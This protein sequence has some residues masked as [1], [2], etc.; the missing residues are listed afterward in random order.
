MYTPQQ[1][2]ARE[3]A[4]PEFR[5]LPWEQQIKLR[6]EYMTKYIMSGQDQELSRTFA[7]LSPD[8]QKE[9]LDKFAFRAPVFENDK[10]GREYTT[11][12]EQFKNEQA[13][14]GQF[15]SKQTS[16]PPTLR[17]SARAQAQVV[18]GNTIQGSALI[19]AGARLGQRLMQALG[20][21]RA[22]KN[23]Q[24]AVFGDDMKKG[25]KWLEYNVSKEKGEFR[26]KILK[27]VG[28][29]AGVGGDL[30]AGYGVTQ[31]LPT[32]ALKTVAAKAAASIPTKGAVGM[33][34]QS[35]LGV[36]AP[37]A[38][39]TAGEGVTMAVRGEIDR[40]LNGE[41]SVFSKNP[42]FVEIARDF[43]E[44][45]FLDFAIGL[46]GHGI[47]PTAKNIYKMF[48][49]Y[50]TIE[51]GLSGAD[52]QLVRSAIDSWA[53]GETVSEVALNRLPEEVRDYLKQVEKIIDKHPLSAGKTVA[54]STM[55]ELNENPELIANIVAHNNGK[56]A[57]QL[58]DGTWR[59]RDLHDPKFLE[60]FDSTTELLERL[61]ELNNSK[62][63][64]LA[65]LDPEAA[66]L[67]EGSASNLAPFKKPVEGI[68][69][70][71]D[72]RQYVPDISDPTV[73]EATVLSAKKGG[74][75][76]YVPVTKRTAVNTNEASV[77]MERA[78]TQGATAL[79]AHITDDIAEVAERRPVAGRIAPTA[80]EANALIV[81]RRPLDDEGFAAV[82]TQAKRA[83]AKYALRSSEDDLTRAFALREGYDGAVLSNGQVVSFTPSRIRHI[84]ERV[85]TKTGLVVGLSPEA[86]TLH[87]EGTLAP[88]A[89][90]RVKLTGQVAEGETV[91]GASG[92][93]K[94]L[95]N[96][97]DNLDGQALG[98]F[99]EFYLKKAET[100]PKFVKVITSPAANHKASV[101]VK[102]SG[103]DGIVLTVPAR[104]T[105]P[106]TRQKFVTQFLST[107]DA[108]LPKLNKTLSEG[109]IL[110][111]EQVSRSYSRYI[112]KYE[113]PELP[114]QAKRQWFEKV[115]SDKGLA[116]A[117][118]EQG[119][120]RRFVLQA[121]DPVSTKFNKIEGDT[122]EDVMDEF[123]LQNVAEKQL[124]TAL[125]S[126]GFR[127]VRVRNPAPGTPRFRITKP[128][129][130]RI[131]GWEAD[132]IPTL[133]RK[134]GYRPKLSSEFAPSLAVIDPKAG[135]F[136]YS[137]GVVVGTNSSVRKMLDNFDDF[138][139]REVERTFI[140]GDGVVHFTRPAEIEVHIPQAGIRRTF[141]S[142][143]D[144]LAFANGSWRDLNSLHRSAAE[145]GFELSGRNGTFTLVGNGER[146]TAKDLKELSEIL[147]EYPDPSYAPSFHP[148]FDSQW[149]QLKDTFKGIPDVPTFRPSSYVP[150]PLEEYFRTDTG[151]VISAPI[152]KTIKSRTRSASYFST[153]LRDWMTKRL[154]DADAP[155][156][157]VAF[158][159]LLQAELLAANE[160]SRGD[161]LTHLLYRTRGSKRKLG[162]ALSEERRLVIS[163]WLESSDKKAFEAAH[164]MT[165]DEIEIASATRDWFNKL[166]VK[167]GID[168]ALYLEDYLP[169]VREMLLSMDPQDLNLQDSAIELVTKLFGERHIPASVRFW[170]E[171]ARIEEF[172]M[173]FL[174]RDPVALMRR[175]NLHG[176]RRLYMD[177]A[178]KRFKE[179]IDKP[180]IPAEVKIASDNYYKSLLGLDYSQNERYLKRSLS[181]FYSSLEQVLRQSALGE[182]VDPKLMNR[183]RKANEPILSNLWSVSYASYMGWRPWLV[184]R[185]SLQPWTTVAPRFGFTPVARA[186]ETFSKDPDKIIRTLRAEGHIID[187]PPIV[188]DLA[189]TD[190]TL[191]A[192]TG[193][194]L[195]AFTNSDQYTRAITYLTVKGEWDEALSKV[196]AGKLK[197]WDEFAVRSQVN[198]MRPDVQHT[199]RGRLE[200]SGL[201]DPSRP[202]NDSIL[203][204]AFHFYAHEAINDTMFLYRKTN[205]PAAFRAGIVGKLFGQFGTYSAG[206]IQNFL[207]GARMGTKA[208]RAAYFARF[209]V[210]SFGLYEAFKAIG[211]N[212]RN[213]LPWV[214]ATFSGGPW[215]SAAYNV[216][217]AFSSDYRGRQAR[218]ELDRYLPVNAFEMSSALLRGEDVVAKFNLPIG[219]VPGGSEIASVIK[220]LQYLDEGDTK[221]AL[222]TA[223][224][225]P[226][227]PDK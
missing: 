164:K 184:I 31:G 52:R 43:G 73:K 210:A 181:K 147:R 74:T 207:T 54:N 83:K 186:V 57:T 148:E 109:A 64:R 163:D 116:L 58:E 157:A 104:I 72:Y 222:L 21:N 18:I 209:A 206:Y 173:L 121:R 120:K 226:V 26:T 200:A 71:L 89:L 140:R 40:A 124:A 195:R 25:Q 183:L 180:H 96:L 47:I 218:A 154:M 81:L 220:S 138:A 1:W 45:A 204:G 194:A 86:K 153:P 107:L 123:F 115:A 22:A 97:T 216:L 170:A 187:P 15:L 53:R 201:F 103:A 176:H 144:A 2:I 68:D 155:D 98:E 23:V 217:Q 60:T 150:P 61:S 88:Q 203:Q 113:F 114:A 24:Q 130:V 175:Y 101:V 33:A 20:M 94:A 75:S 19:R 49:G 90:V 78:K 95:S 41:P 135:T 38:I 35:A 202:T 6:M 69:E 10:I 177:A 99:A 82:R 185:N 4:T 225:A 219:F 172:T 117:E 139:K 80:Q 165:T 178:W 66:R 146:R 8:R 36:V 85:S 9:L 158:R 44:G 118:V 16:E 70:I 5:A 214:P 223:L 182:P 143:Q 188:D 205:K 39:E 129:G 48:K 160:T 168:P 12:T 167:F 65:D 92:A 191:G 76:R 111:P 141:S 59:L 102:R 37:A 136:E 32:A 215:A 17:A 125:A 145:K 131:P 199:V 196:R 84:D 166:M 208:Q 132:D 91:L 13:Q 51:K 179:A 62:I 29:I 106:A 105:N 112:T 193:K 110:K 63:R 133:L 30:L 221:R 213:F 134:S 28:T 126:D 46:V 189:R 156:A 34:A 212:A 161:L 108:Q 100:P 67:Y 77:I 152:R 11:L 197:S 162:K 127:L 174:E 227:I 211:V 14:L 27:T 137:S 151:D 87:A 50:D 93:A 56:A 3:Q 79:Y 122:I 55:D 7:S 119:G 128:T 142:P 42:Q 169:R 190:T 192:L 198:K 224:S 171:N 149:H 159:D